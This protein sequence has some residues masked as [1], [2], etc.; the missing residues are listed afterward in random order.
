[1]RG[2]DRAG[3]EL[4]LG[5]D[6]ARLGISGENGWPEERPVRQGCRME[7]SGRE[8]L[9]HGMLKKRFLFFLQ[10]VFRA[11]SVNTIG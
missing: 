10:S 5:E 1:M 11:F 9:E 6:A 8:K 7:K 2:D 4:R 3:G